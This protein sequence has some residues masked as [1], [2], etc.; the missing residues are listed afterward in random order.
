MNVNISAGRTEKMKP[1]VREYVTDKTAGYER[2]SH[3]FVRIILSAHSELLR[4]CMGYSKFE[5]R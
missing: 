1:T 5:F 2:L 3:M 4:P